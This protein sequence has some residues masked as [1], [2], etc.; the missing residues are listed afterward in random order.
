MGPQIIQVIQPRYKIIINALENRSINK[1]NEIQ[2]TPKTD[3]EINLTGCGIQF[4]Y[5]YRYSSYLLQT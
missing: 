2:F 4:V 5:K 3:K 1:L